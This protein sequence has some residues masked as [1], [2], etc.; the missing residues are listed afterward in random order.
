MKKHHIKI[1]LAALVISLTA[2]SVFASYYAQ[3][4]T[5]YRGEERPRGANDIASLG[6]LK[7]QL[8]TS[9][10]NVDEK[11]SESNVGDAEQNG[12][13]LPIWHL[14]EKK[15]GEIADKSA[16]S[17]A[18]VPEIPA[19]PKPVSSLCGKNEVPVIK[20]SQF[21]GCKM[22]SLPAQQAKQAQPVKIQ[23]TRTQAPATCESKGKF[24]YTGPDRK[25]ILY[26]MCIDCLTTDFVTHG[27]KCK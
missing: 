3:N 20:N 26:G 17:P 4:K 5:Y 16:I 12:T 11:G 2:V 13:N 19:T 8:Y 9:I 10:L 14:E 22:L 1:W 23:V 27:G 7:N 25:G 18:T 21:A 6:D 15:T 24:T